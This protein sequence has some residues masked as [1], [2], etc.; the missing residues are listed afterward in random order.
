MY[1][2]LLGVHL[3]DTYI[4]ICINVK[5]NIVFINSSTTRERYGYIRTFT[6]PIRQ[7]QFAC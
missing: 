2:Q 4:I 3:Q 1:L 5:V 6:T 7:P